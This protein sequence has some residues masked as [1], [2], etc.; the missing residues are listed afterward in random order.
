M[1]IVGRRGHVNATY[2]L[3]RDEPQR[4]REFTPMLHT[5]EAAGEQGDA[6]KGEQ[7]RA[8]SAALGAGCFGGIRCAERRNILNST[9]GA[10][11]S[12]TEQ[13]VSDPGRGVLAY[14]PWDI[15]PPCPSKMAGPSSQDLQF[16]LLR[17]E[18]LFHGDTCEFAFVDRPSICVVFAL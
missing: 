3:P 4:V 11:P 15:L 16:S 12:R 6:Q 14:R 5:C 9:I 13:I 17:H 10:A 18:H 1:R 2:T 7:F 8:P